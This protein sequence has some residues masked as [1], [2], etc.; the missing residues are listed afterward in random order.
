MYFALQNSPD[1]QESAGSHLLA[2]NLS[3]ETGTMLEHIRLQLPRPVGFWWLD[4]TE[5]FVNK[6]ALVV[7]HDRSD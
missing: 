4:G 1:G 3:D 5:M 2:L 7:F 6:I